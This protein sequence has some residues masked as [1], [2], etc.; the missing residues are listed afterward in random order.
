MPY[1]HYVSCSL[2]A[3]AEHLFR[4]VPPI[5]PHYVSSSHLLCGMPVTMI[6]LVEPIRVGRIL[7][8]LNVSSDEGPMVPQ[9]NDYCCDT[10]I[11]KGHIK[12]RG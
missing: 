11:T 5:R 3:G 7:E 12:I 4:W 2:A 6:R 1:T 10:L 8:E 9:S